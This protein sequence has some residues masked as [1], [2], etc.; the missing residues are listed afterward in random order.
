MSQHQHSR[1]FPAAGWIVCLL[2]LWAGSFLG[3][4]AAR[5]E[6]AR[7]VILPEETPSPS[8]V[9]VD[10]ASQPILA[11]YYP[12]YARLDGFLP[13]DL[14][15]EL[16]T[17]IH[18]AFAG[19]DGSGRVV[20]ANPA[21]DRLNLAGLRQL[22]EEHPGLSV[23]LSVGGWDDSEHF[24]TA[25]G[26]EEGRRAFAESASALVREF[27]LD[28][29][30]LDW[31]FPVSGGKAGNRHDARDG[32]NY[33]LLLEAVREELDRLR[34]EKGRDYL[35]TVALP[36]GETAMAHLDPAGMSPLVDYFF[37][38]GYDLWGPWDSR[39]G[40]NAPLSAAGE[41]PSV[42][43]AVERYLA[44]GVPPEKLVLGMPFYGYLYEVP[45]PGETAQGGPFTAA[46]SVGYDAVVSQYL[47]E[48]ER[49]FSSPGEVP[50]LSGEGW[51]LT[52]DDPSSIAAKVRYAKEK[53]LAGAGAWELSQD[54]SARLLAAAY[55]G[56]AG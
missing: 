1:F 32:E 7:A 46:R 18:Y 45:G 2:L 52:Y 53:R 21:E 41:A 23:L 55:E 24:S 43:G 50:Y 29:L 35:L 27:D 9:S 36:P 33:L 56:L 44:A 22:R 40:L 26:T 3:G 30:D 49:G 15:A 5:Q 37:L 11:G 4:W 31:E 17:H 38:M 51:F 16:L 28:G 19:M 42:S 39:V 14:A 8:V 34:A 48:G 20:L 54:R 13:G 12:W 47:A 25:A 10:A 6:A